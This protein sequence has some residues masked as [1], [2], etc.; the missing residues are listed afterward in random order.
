MSQEVQ[1][2]LVVH[3]TAATR[4]RVH[5]S[6]VTGRPE[7]MVFNL[8]FL[9]ANR[10][11]PDFRAALATLQAGHSGT[12]LTLEMRGPWPPYNFCPALADED[13]S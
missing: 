9:V 13:R 2:A 7:R 12:G 3:S 5:A 8:S 11:L 6:A 4:L 1:D 10:T